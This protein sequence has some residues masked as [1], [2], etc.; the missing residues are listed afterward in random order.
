MTGDELRAAIKK[1]TRVRVWIRLNASSSGVYCP[2][3]KK[4]ARYLVDEAEAHDID[5]FEAELESGGLL[6]PGETWLW[7]G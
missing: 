2:I 1:A 3:G 5:E 6:S 4:I 7:I